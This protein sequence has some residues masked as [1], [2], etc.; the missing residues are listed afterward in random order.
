MYLSTLWYASGQNEP[1]GDSFEHTETDNKGFSAFQAQSAKLLP[2]FEQFFRGGGG[3]APE[4]DPDSALSMGIERVGST[5]E[6]CARLIALPTRTS[7]STRT[8]E[9]GF[10]AP[11]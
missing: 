2:P 10:H 11:I 7:M 9:S 6:R 1:F 4:A 8:C 3:W 5:P